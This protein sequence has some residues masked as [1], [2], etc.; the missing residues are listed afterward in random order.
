MNL[1]DA[2]IE[3]SRKFAKNAV[4]TYVILPCV[5]ECRLRQ[6]TISLKEEQMLEGYYRKAF[7]E[8]ADI[9]LSEFFGRDYFNDL[10]ED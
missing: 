7:C 1:N 9:T 6:F 5:A 8:G 10:E 4:V 3:V 2:I